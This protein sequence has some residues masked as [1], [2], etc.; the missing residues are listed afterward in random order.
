MNWLKPLIN[1]FS[2]L[3]GW[4]IV[5]ALI[6]AGAF[7]MFGDGG[8]AGAEDFQMLPVPETPY[9]A[10]T[11]GVVGVEGGVIEIAARSGG[12]FREVFVEAGETVE[13]GQLLAEQIDDAEQIALRDQR[14]ALE[15]AELSVE[16]ARN[17]LEIEQRGLERAQIQY[18]ADA[19]SEQ[20]FDRAR[21]G[22]V[23]AEISVRTQEIALMRAQTNVETAEANLE[24]RKIRAPV[25]GRIVEVLVRPGVGASTT[26]VSSAFLLVP[27][28]PRIV[29][30]MI[31]EETLQSV[32]EGQTVEIAPTFNPGERF[33]GR[34]RR[35]SELFQTNDNQRGAPQLAV[36]IIAED[37]PLRIG[38]RVTVRFVKPDDQ[39]QPASV[40]D[41]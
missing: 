31:T 5:L 15:T 8:G 33:T 18:E 24:L 7:F 41:A 35:I 26:Q 2:G 1:F 37:L 34:V 11:T 30:T 16:T 19:L 3:W 36:E 20:E 32:F 23:S 14:A 17:H 10:V 22:V 25:D 39:P 27:D 12:T 4:L 38:Q 40:Q 13:A 21:D 9:A 6:G 28:A 29:T